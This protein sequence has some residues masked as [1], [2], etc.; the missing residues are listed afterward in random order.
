MRVIL[1]GTM[2][3]QHVNGASGSVESLAVRTVLKLVFVCKQI[4]RFSCKIPIIWGQGHFF[5]PPLCIYT[6]QSKV[7]NIIW[8][9]SEIELTNICS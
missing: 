6:E 3:G 8:D 4:C 7:L 9:H 1:A 2:R 5:S